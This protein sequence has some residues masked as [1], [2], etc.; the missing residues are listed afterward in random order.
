MPHRR[1]IYKIIL[2]VNQPVLGRNSHRLSP[3]AAFSLA[4]MALT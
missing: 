2:Q 1:T 4:R 3:V